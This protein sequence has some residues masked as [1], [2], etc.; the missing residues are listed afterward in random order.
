MVLGPTASSPPPR[1]PAQPGDGLSPATARCSWQDTCVSLLS[2]A[3]PELPEAPVHQEGDF[4]SPPL[5]DVAQVNL[6]RG[7][8]FTAEKLN[9]QPLVRDGWV[10]RAGKPH[11]QPQE[12]ALCRAL[13][14]PALFPK[15]QRHLLCTAQLGSQARHLLPQPSHLPEF[16]P[17]QSQFVP[18]GARKAD[19]IRELLSLSQSLQARVLELPFLSLL[20]QCFPSA[21]ALATGKERGKGTSP[22]CY[23]REGKQHEAG[24]HYPTK[25]AAGQERALT[26]ETSARP[27]AAPAPERERLST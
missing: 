22:G 2:G 16:F 8:G 18:A 19:L 9:Q 1:C 5:P 26:V 25:R 15:A 13:L 10:A 3:R 14:I 20:R 4:G 11:R 12:S 21:P 17:Q 6:A 7:R 24:S 23:T 27:S